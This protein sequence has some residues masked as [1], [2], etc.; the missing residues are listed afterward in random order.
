MAGPVIPDPADPTIVL[1][2]P[3][4]AAIK[5][6]LVIILLGL[7]HTSVHLKRSD[8]AGVN[9]LVVPI[10]SLLILS[11]GVWLVGFGLTVT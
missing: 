2:E 1:I 5:S 3:G 4:E 11:L 9:E 6:G 10:R 8:A 7:V